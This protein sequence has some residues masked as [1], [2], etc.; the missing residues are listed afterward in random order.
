MDTDNLSTE[1]YKA[2]IIEAERLVHDLTLQFGVLASSCIDEAEYLKKSKEL[3]QEIME[4]DD[5]EL[6]DILFG[7]VPE[8][9][10]LDS[11]LNQM[12]KNIDEVNEIPVDK[13]HYEF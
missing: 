1:A 13:R 7:N 8:R 4:L 11:T 12:I 9:D 3:A 5:Y 2:V 6:E 10:K